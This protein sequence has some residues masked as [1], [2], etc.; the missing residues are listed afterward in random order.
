MECER[1]QRKSEIMSRV[2]ALSLTFCMALKKSGTAIAAIKPKTTAVMTISI[3][4]KP[5]LFLSDFMVISPYSS[6]QV[7]GTF[8]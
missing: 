8:L 7:P 2:A 3:K 6:L 1:A 5:D 4:V